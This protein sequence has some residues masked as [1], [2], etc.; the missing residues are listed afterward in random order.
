MKLFSHLLA[1]IL[2]FI[3]LSQLSFAMGSVY[4]TERP[5]PH[6]KISS[7]LLADPPTPTELEITCSDASTYTFADINR[8]GRDFCTSI[9]PACVESLGM[10]D[11][12]LL[13]SELV[14]TARINSMP[15]ED[16]TTNNAPTSPETF[17]KMKYKIGSIQAPISII[18]G[19]SK[20][21]RAKAQFWLETDKFSLLEVLNSTSVSILDPMNNALAEDVLIRAEFA[22]F[23]TPAVNR[24][25]VDLVEG[26]FIVPYWSL[27]I[28]VDHGVVTG[29]SWDN[30]CGD[31]T[32][33]Q[34]VANQQCGMKQTECVGTEEGLSC[35]LK[36]YVAWRGTD[37]DGK[38]MTSVNS[39]IRNFRLFSFSFLFDY[40]ARTSRVVTENL[41]DT[42]PP[43]PDWD[44]F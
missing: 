28:D 20:R 39:S 29:L 11:S 25:K 17:D 6:A 21:P 32:Q 5:I 30:S 4:P 2:G 31:C 27:V 18:V 16:D 40:A 23:T 35:D 7:F 41:P 37:V 9:P 33:R 42:F 12:P 36:F 14:A 43:L 8:A 13:F 24:A 26:R 38:Y 15:P 22:N 10:K 19:D 1:P 3:A 44:L 34:C